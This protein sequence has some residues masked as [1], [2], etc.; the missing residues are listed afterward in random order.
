MVRPMAIPKEVTIRRVLIANRG[1]IAIRI[2]RTLRELDIESVA[3][4]SDADRK[5]NHVLLADMALP[6]GPAPAAESYLVI[7]K[8]IA[9]CKESGADAVHPGYGFLSENAVFAERLKAEGIILIG[10][11]AEAML[12]MGS[13]TQ[14]RKAMLEAK[15]PVVPGES[16]PGGNGFDDA[17]SAMVA[18]ESIGYPVLIKAAA[19]GGGKG[20]RLVEGKADFEA[21]FDGAKREAKNAFGDDTVFVEKAVIRPRHVE[22]QVFADQH[23][24]VVHLG[25]RDCSM[26]RRHQ[27]VIEES[28]CP[29]V[30][31]ELRIQ[32][33]EAA[34]CAAKSCNYVGA[35]TV[36]FLLTS[37]GEYYFLEMNTRLQVEHPVTEMVYSVDLVAWQILVAEGK[38]LPLNQDEINK[39]RRGVAMEC[40]IYAEDAVRFLP[41]PGT[42]QTLR[43]PAGPYVRNDSCAY[44]GVEISMY[45]DPL[46]SKLITWGDDRASALARMRRALAE[47]RV[48]GIETNIAFHQRVMKHAGFIAG[49]YDTGTIERDEELRVAS[50]ASG[51]ELEAGIAVAALRDHMGGPKS[52]KSD[53][54]GQAVSGSAWRTPLSTWRSR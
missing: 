15:I 45:Y 42:I 18:A 2:I 10:P 32:M 46:I 41:S 47:Y 54:S 23:G 26:Q 12:L 25:E 4:F 35:G 52:L 51:A 24:N 40:R 6:I 5:A 28:P 20:M 31:E 48:V 43:V 34:I 53:T 8:I 37:S 22:I 27:K 33:G 17:A 1:E 44:E 7:D 38:A 19:G 39:R 36:E 9:A 14:A 3:V 13:K 29:D 49:E 16:G 50:H 30:S 21:A 11:P